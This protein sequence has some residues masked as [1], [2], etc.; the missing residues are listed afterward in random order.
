MSCLG[1]LTLDSS[2]PLSFM[3]S[4]SLLLLDRLVKFL[5]ICSGRWE[6]W[7]VYE[8]YW[9]QRQTLLSHPKKAASTQRPAICHS[10]QKVSLLFTMFAFLTPAIQNGLF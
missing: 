4:L 7:I 6:R 2:L 9:P 5:Q 10:P 1:N 3:R 8:N